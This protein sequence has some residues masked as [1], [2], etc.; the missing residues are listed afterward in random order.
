MIRVLVGLAI[1]CVGCGGSGGTLTGAGGNTG[2]RTGIGGFTGSIGGF[3][4]LAATSGFGMQCGATP[5][6]PPLLP[7]NV[8]I[9]LD[10]SLSMNDDMNNMSCQG[11]CGQSS[12][13]AAAVSAINAAVADTLGTVNWGLELF[14]TEGVAACGTWTGVY[15]DTAPDTATAI[16]TVLHNQSTPN[17]GVYSSGTRL[18]RGAIE[19]A[20]S[21]FLGRVDVNPKYIVLISDGLPMCAPQGAQL[22]DD[23]GAT[24]DAITAAATAGFPTFVVGLATGEASVHASMV[25]LGNAGRVGNVWPDP[26]AGHYQAGNVHTAL[27][28]VADATT[29]CTFLIPSS[30]GPYDRGIGVRLGGTDIPYDAVDGWVYVDSTQSAV[31]LHGKAC[32]A[33]KAGDPVSIIFR[34]LLP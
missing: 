18:T 8:L 11:G 16:A 24:V 30:H 33:A 5:S 10:T 20:R 12:K 6:A 17:G 23:T 32:A 25:M 29:G 22:A 19:A 7:P 1:V 2:T 4:G 28:T 31:Q 34:C 27:R 15:V 21:Y 3:T 14:A 9:V 13:W 26:T